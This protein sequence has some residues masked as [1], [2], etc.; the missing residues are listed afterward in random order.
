[1]RRALAIVG[2]GAGLWACHHGPDDA[3]EHTRDVRV[4]ASAESTYQ[5][6]ARKPRVAVGIAESR[7]AEGDDAK[8]VADRLADSASTCLAS[9]E[10]EGKL[11]DGA[12]RILLPFDAG[13]IAQPPQVV[14]AD[15]PGVA[16]NGLLCIV[17]PARMIA[18]PPAD[19]G[20]RT[21]ALEV[22]WGRDVGA[23]P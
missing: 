16:A 10:K 4:D 20:T 17:A 23:G 22:A 7:G 5:Y 14:L 13:G 8:R 12:L 3:T 15:G 18:L 6:V 21:L 19:A 1:M 9:L 2:L 11:V